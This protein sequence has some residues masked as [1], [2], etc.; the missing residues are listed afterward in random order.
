MRANV[1]ESE[2]CNF[3]TQKRNCSANPRSIFFFSPPSAFIQE[4]NLEAPKRSF[5]SIFLAKNGVLRLKNKAFVRRILREW[6]FAVQKR[7]FRSQPFF[8]WVHNCDFLVDASKVE[9]IPRAA[10]NLSR[11]IQTPATVT[12]NDHCKATCP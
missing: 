9:N 7:S 6:H 4:W 11:G 12:R 10:K 3:E 8:K 1:Y 5:S 2:K